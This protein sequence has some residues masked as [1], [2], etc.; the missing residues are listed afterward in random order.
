MARHNS[1]L[2]VIVYGPTSA[3]GYQ[4]GQMVI[5][6]DVLYELETMLLITIAT[7]A[8]CV[9]LFV[10]WGTIAQLMMFMTRV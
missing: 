9:C 10:M 1:C 4:L 3:A 5:S 2:T 7:I 8:M 6:V